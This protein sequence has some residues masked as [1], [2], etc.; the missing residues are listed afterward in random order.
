MNG[1][2]QVAR[3]VLRDAKKVLVTEQERVI[4][5]QR[6][7]LFSP[8]NRFARLASIGEGRAAPHPRFSIIW[9]SVKSSLRQ[10]LCLLY[11]SAG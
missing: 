10:A 2:L 11:F 9:C 4:G 3:S 7:S 5:R 8:G 6:Q 1:L